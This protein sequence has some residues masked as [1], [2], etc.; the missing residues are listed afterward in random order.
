MFRRK[1]DE[2]GSE[3]S[4]SEA[5]STAEG[6]VVKVPNSRAQISKAS[7]DFLVSSRE[8][9]DRSER[10]SLL[11]ERGTAK[12]VSAVASRFERSARPA[13]SVS[14]SEKTFRTAAD[15]TPRRTEFDRDS[16][17]KGSSAGSSVTSDFS[18]DRDTGSKRVLT[19]GQDTVLKGEISTCDRL[20]VQGTVD[21][22]LTD[23]HTIEITETGE[24]KGSATIENA[25]I[26]GLFDGE[27]QVKGRLTVYG[28]GR[29]TGKISYSEIEIQRGGMISGKVV[30]SNSARSDERFEEDD[31]DAD[32]K[33][34]LV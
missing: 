24:F 31:A 8:R 9:E 10:D 16:R 15:A 25:E 30:V 34:A 7:N 22:V 11:R 17:M 27:L 19:V 20:I 32:S 1:E 5:E 6:N 3:N 12:S 4:V 26:S 29:V 21:A 28:T 2:L 18:L 13:A 14:T 23:V 33:M